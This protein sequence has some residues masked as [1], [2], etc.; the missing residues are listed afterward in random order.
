MRR[1]Y[2]IE[3]YI[4]G[5]STFPPP[6]H[7]PP[8]TCPPAPPIISHIL[9]EIP[10]SHVAHEAL[11]LQQ[12]VHI[13]QTAKCPPPQ[14][15]TKMENGPI[16]SISHYLK[17][18]SQGSMPPDP[19]IR[20]IFLALADADPLQCE[21]QEPQVCATFTKFSTTSRTSI[22]CLLSST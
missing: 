4:C 7:P 1:F 12:D 11:G 5:K 18:N 19:L 17:K 20:S 16:F 22:S 6:P 3:F 13:P 10:M 14:G 8:T 15:L 9:N 2:A 21:C